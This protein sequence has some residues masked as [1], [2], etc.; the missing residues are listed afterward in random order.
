M[1]APRRRSCAPRRARGR[2]RLAS[3]R[4]AVRP[5]IV[6]LRRFHPSPSTG[7]ANSPSGRGGSRSG[8][9]AF[10][11]VRVHLHE[12][13]GQQEEIGGER[14]DDDERGELAHAGVEL[15]AG[16]ADDDET[17]HEN[18]GSRQQGVAHGAEGDAH[19]IGRRASEFVPGPPVLAQEVHRVVDHDPQRHGR[20]H[21]ERDPHLSD[22][23]APDPEAQRAGNQVRNEAR[24]PELQGSQREDEDER[25]SDE[26]DGGPDEHRD[27]V[28]PAEMRE[29]QRVA[30]ALG[31]RDVRRTVGQPSQRAPVEGDHLVGRDRPRRHRHPGGRLVD[32]DLVVEIETGGKRQL[33]EEQI[34]RGQFLA[35]RQPVLGGVVAVHAHVEPPEG[36][37][38]DVDVDRLGLRPVPLGERRDVGQIGG[39]ADSLRRARIER[40]LH[41]VDAGEVV[42]GEIRV[43]AKLDALVEI[44]EEDVVQ[45]VAGYRGEER[46][47]DRSQPPSQHAAPADHELAERGHR[48]IAAVP[49]RAHPDRQQREQRRQKGHRERERRADPERDEG[50]QMTE[51]RDLREVH[52]QKAQRGGQAGEEDRLE[53]HPH[54]FDD[55]IPLGLA[56]RAGGIAPHGVDQRRKDVHAAGDRDR[57][58][59]DRRDR[60]GRRHRES[61]PAAETH[62]GHDRQRDHEHDRERPAQPSRQEHQHQRHRREGRRD[63]YLEVVQ[64][65]LHEGLVEDDQAG[66]ANV[67]AGKS[68]PHL[69]REP[70]R[71]RRDPGALDHLVLARRMD[72]DAYA[73][74]PAVAGDQAPRETRLGQGDRA[75]PG[76]LVGIA[77]NVLVDE[78]ADQDVVAVGRDVLE[79]DER[80]DAGRVGNRPGPLGEPCGGFEREGGGGVAVRRDDGEEDV[81]A[82]PVGVLDRLARTALRVVAGGVEAGIGRKLEKRRAARRDA[83]ERQGDGYDRPPQIDDPA[84]E[85][86]LY[87]ELRPLLRAAHGQ[88]PEQN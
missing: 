78:I 18:E 45:L 88:P 51:R 62:R 43:A 76:P 60:G 2:E 71:E 75:Y 24:E 7:G 83:G 53:I 8:G 84:A 49:R 26:S 72:R 68:L 65:H 56:G 82:L 44:V 32:V 21:R 63:Q 36:I 40:I 64:R 46:H 70:A 10:A 41:G 87:R 61:G 11:R 33:V 30:G 50:A 59:H 86:R 74:D 77:D 55:R 3:R 25:N 69:G 66:H 47:R 29:H 6:E 4:H 15:E 20:H 67:D 5:D 1:S 85:A 58:H 27:D 34:L 22:R 13:R 54:R 73:A 31:A 35:C 9:P 80:V 37:R 38:D 81:Q 17:R 48:R 14:Q 39:V 19:R 52:A 12:Q 57:Q 79:V 28:A 16:E 42:D 23:Q